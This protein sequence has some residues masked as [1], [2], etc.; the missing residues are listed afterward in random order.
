MDEYQFNEMLRNIVEANTRTSEN[1]ATMT[2][3]VSGLLLEAT[4]DRLS[5]DQDEG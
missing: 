3:C 1:L 4:W 2:E 5:N